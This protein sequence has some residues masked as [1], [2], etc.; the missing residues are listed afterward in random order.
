MKQGV[1]EAIEEESEWEEN[2]DAPQEAPG[3]LTVVLGGGSQALIR[4]FYLG[5]IVA[6]KRPPNSFQTHL[7]V[8]TNKPVKHLLNV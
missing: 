6:K 2:A 1:K 4:L 5:T 3:D 8:F 7:L